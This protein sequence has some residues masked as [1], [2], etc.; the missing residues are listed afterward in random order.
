MDV[1]EGL[2][3]IPSDS[4]DLVMTSPPYW[5]LRD[6][7]VNGQIGIE[8]TPAEYVAKMVAVFHEVRRVLK[9]SGTLWLNLGDSYAT[10]VS[11]EGKRNSGLKPKDLVGIPWRV[12]FALQADGWYLRQD[13]IWAKP[14][15][16]PESVTDR[17]TKSHEYIFLFTKNESYYYNNEAI[18]EKQEEISI[19]RAFSTNNMSARKLGGDEPYAISGRAQDKTYAIMREKIKAGWKPTRN[20]RSVWTVTT[21]PFTSDHFSR[22][23][24]HFAMFP[25]ELCETPIKAGLPDEV[26]VKCGKI[27]EQVIKELR[28]EAISSISITTNQGNPR[29][30]GAIYHP[31]LRKDVIG[32]SVCGCGAGFRG[33]VALDPF[34]GSGTVGEAVRKWKPT[35]SVFL[36]ELNPAYVPLIKERVGWGQQTIGGND[37]IAYEEVVGNANVY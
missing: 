1:M 17:C 14:N 4:I 20:K 36:I 32:L 23:R 34:A 9:P 26:C 10:I 18:K 12:A 25:L 16:M 28:G 24:S 35:A 22:F 2:A 13:I 5:G 30:G 7:G 31:L 29:K 3:R 27:R 21:K 6:Y 37:L 19:R 33:G 8:A 11:Q 15:P